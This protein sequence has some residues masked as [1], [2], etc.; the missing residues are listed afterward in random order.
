MI[1]TKNPNA[2]AP[3]TYNRESDDAG[4]DSPKRVQELVAPFLKSG[5]IVL[6]LGIGTGQAVEGYAEKGVQVVG[7]D[8]DP[9]MLENARKN[10]G[11]EAE[12]R[13]GDINEPLPVDDLLDSVDVV[14]AV[15]VLEF[16]N[17]IGNIVD[18]AEA[19]LK[20]GGIFVLTVELVSEDTTIPTTEHY[21]EADVTVYRHTTS[22]IESLLIGRGFILLKTE[23]YE[24][25]S[26]N[27]TE[28]GKVPY[29]VFLV[30]KL[31]LHV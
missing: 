17:N 19:V 18:Q 29:Q 2:V 14:Q 30:Q 1:D 20:N 6:D 11:A 8:H 22:E 9:S 5:V 12:L 3:E 27:D 10:V 23:S 25:Y 24:G 28:S 21:P 13:V 26:R 15:G 16:A 7:I 4:W 31:P